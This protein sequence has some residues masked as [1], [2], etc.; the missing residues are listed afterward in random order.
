MVASEPN[1]P[2]AEKEMEVARVNI[3]PSVVSQ[4]HIELLDANGT[5]IPN[6]LVKS[7]E[8]EYSIVFCPPS[9][10]TYYGNVAIADTPVSKF[11]VV[12]TPPPVTAVIVE[13]YSDWD[14]PPPFVG[15]QYVFF[16]T[17]VHF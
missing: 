10:G 14:S 6:S 1:I 13:G 15:Q 16:L 4:V 8:Q 2:K 3:P 9:P 7:N 12:V 11:E 17:R 5:K